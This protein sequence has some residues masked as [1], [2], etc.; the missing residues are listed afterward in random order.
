MQQVGAALMAMAV[1]L[2]LFYKQSVAHTVRHNSARQEFPTSGIIRILSNNVQR[3]PWTMH[4]GVDVSKLLKEA[5]IV[6]LQEDFSHPCKSYTCNMDRLSIFHAGI[7][8][9]SKPWR[10][11]DSGL[12]VYSKYRWKSA[13]FFPFAHSA[14]GAGDI[15]ADKGIVCIDYGSFLLCNVH[16]QSDNEQVNQMQIDEIFQILQK[17]YYYCERVVIVGDFNTDMRTLKVSGFQNW[18]TDKPTYPVLPCATD[19][20]DGALCKGDVLSQIDRMIVDEVADH[21]AV[22]LKTRL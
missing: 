20:L 7:Y 2:A 19:W 5:E 21:Y 10:I 14:L 8:N 17:N 1:G 11:A 12:S 9:R 18:Y 13:R 4:K 15:F 3:L 22:T 6:C 16:L